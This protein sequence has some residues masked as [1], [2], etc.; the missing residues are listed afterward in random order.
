MSH[1]TCHSSLSSS[2]RQRGFAFLQLSWFRFPENE[3][4]SGEN[5]RAADERPEAETFSAQKPAEQNRARRSDKRD[6]LQ[7]RD[8][9]SRQQPVKEQE[10]E[11]RAGDRQIEKAKRRARGP[12]KLQRVSVEQESGNEQRDKTED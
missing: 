6:R 7:I 11:S 5:K 8:R 10:R 4:H 3:P 9:H 12:M 2:L 1:V